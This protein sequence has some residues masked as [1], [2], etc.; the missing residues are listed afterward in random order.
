MEGEH[1]VPHGIATTILSLGLGGGKISLR[2]A[3]V[4]S[5][6]QLDLTQACIDSWLFNTNCVFPLWKTLLD[7]IEDVIGVEL[8]GK[9]DYYGPNVFE[10]LKGVHVL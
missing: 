7:I 10:Q 9:A 2:E 5:Q 8:L 6:A 4:Y 1:D 3:M